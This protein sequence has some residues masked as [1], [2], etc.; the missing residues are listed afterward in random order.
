[1]KPVIQQLRKHALLQPD[2]ICLQE[3][4]FT[5]TYAQ[6]MELADATRQQLKLAGLRNGAHRVVLSGINSIDLLVLY[7]ALTDLNT[8]I[9]L[10]DP[11]TTKAE[12]ESVLRAVPVNFLILE[13]TI[14]GE[15]PEAR[16]LI[17]PVRTSFAVTATGS[18][19]VNEK[20]AFVHFFSTGSTGQPK[21]FGFPE[22]KQW[23]MAMNLAAHVPFTAAD[24]VL[25]PVSFTH[26]HG[27]IM[28]LPFLL[29]GATVFYL[30]PELLQPEYMAEYIEKHQLTIMTGVPFQYNRFLESAAKPDALRTLRLAICGSAPMSEYLASSFEQR[31]GVRLNQAYGISEI[32][33]ICIN[34]FEEG[35]HNF[36]SIGKVIQSI[37]Y[38]IVDANDREVPAGSEGELLVRSDFMTDGYLNTDSG[39]LFRNGWMC[40][41]DIVREDEYRNLYILGR[42]STF[43]NVSGYKVYPIEIEKVLLSMKGIKDAIVKAADNEARTQSI[44]AYVNTFYPVPE[45]DIR[46]YCRQH[47]SKYKIPHQIIFVD[48]M[49]RNSIGKVVASKLK[50]EQ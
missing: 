45:E 19:Y 27:Y 11:K 25:C 4:D 18:A 24:K 20:A 32:G 42:K 7:V 21:A 16:H 39:S 48:E 41:Q 15:Q 33:P 2:K 1:M 13:N 5:C 22:D 10:M 8:D 37:E 46:A 28:S 31:F 6:L 47:L 14:F 35:E 38:K 49:P 30:H 40:T 17:Q 29:L 43:I 3:N 23:A 12:M 9:V 34:L 26:G 44:V 36:R 50:N